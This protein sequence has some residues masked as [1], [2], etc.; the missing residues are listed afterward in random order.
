MT[1]GGPSKWPFL[2]PT[3]KFLVAGCE[4]FRYDSSFPNSRYEIRV[5]YPT[6]HDVNV[7]VIGHPCSRRDTQVHTQIEA[8]WIVNFSKSSL[9]L[10]GEIH[11]FIS[12]LFRCPIK[13]TNVLVRHYQEMAADIRIEVEHH[14]VVAGSVQNQ[15]SFIVLGVVQNATEN[16]VRGR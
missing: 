8:R 11:H 14:E 5:P 2:K 12:G 13:I 6:R 9:A 16:T 4:I 15:I 1:G 3:E 7:N 10:L